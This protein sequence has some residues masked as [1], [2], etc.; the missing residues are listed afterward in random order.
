MGEKKVN[1]R[2]HYLFNFIGEIDKNV[3]YKKSRES[4]YELELNISSCNMTSKTYN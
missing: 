3:W 4:K 2:L 1:P